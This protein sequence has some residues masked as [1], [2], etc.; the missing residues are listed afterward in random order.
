MEN[1]AVRGSTNWN[2]ERNVFA[3]HKVYEQGKAAVGLNSTSISSDGQ[4]VILFL[5]FWAFY[6]DETNNNAEHLS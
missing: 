2:E 3:P 4:M 5:F 6:C 1:N